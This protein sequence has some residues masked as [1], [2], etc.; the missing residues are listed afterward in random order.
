[1]ESFLWLLIWGIV[2]ATKDIDKAKDYNP[3]ID[4]MLS[5][6]SGSLGLNRTKLP[7]AENEWDDAVFGKLIKEWLTTLRMAR[8]DTRQ[9]L[10]HMATISVD[11]Q[12]GS[13]WKRACDWLNT[14]C[15]TT[16]N[17]ILQSAFKHLKGVEK[18]TNWEE[19][20]AANEPLSMV[21]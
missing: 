10:T 11:D 19:V 17:K 20:V 9:P 1:M 8:D 2:H 14:Y 15:M 21:F 12:Q 4:L 16:Y 13:E 6:W 5:A 7:T 18:Y 3:G